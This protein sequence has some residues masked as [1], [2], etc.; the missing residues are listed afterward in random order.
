MSDLIVDN[1]EIIAF[2]NKLHEERRQRDTLILEQVIDR[3]NQLLEPIKDELIFKNITF[4]IFTRIPNNLER[5]V[6]INNHFR[7]LLNDPN[8]TYFAHKQDNESNDNVSLYCTL[9]ICINESTITQLKGSIHIRCEAFDAKNSYYY[10]KYANQ[11][12]EIIHRH[13][14]TS[15]FGNY[16]SYYDAKG[17]RRT[18]IMLNSFKLTNS[19][20][21]EY[22]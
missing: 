5:S 18:N 20:N 22:S 19:G 11:I 3:Y 21:I 13:L 4:S 10:K 1:S 7:T 6:D 8:T 16:F 15:N 2:R 14:L 9:L 17:S 12:T